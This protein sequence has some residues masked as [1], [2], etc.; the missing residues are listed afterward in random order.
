MTKLFNNQSQGKPM[1]V[2]V[3]GAA[4]AVA[5]SKLYV[6]GGYTFTNGKPTPVKS[7]Q[8][9]DLTTD[10]WAKDG[11]GGAPPALPDAVHS[12]SAAVLDG[13]LYVAG[14]YG[15][16]GKVRGNF[17]SCGTDGGTWGEAPAMPTPRALLQLTVHQGLLWA[18]GGVGADRVAM[19]TV[20]TY[21]P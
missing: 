2:P 11:A 1:P 8:V 15:A 19:Q 6:V 16:D 13:T 7:V 10:T 9:Y 17:L 5:G 3:A 21:Q 20:E 4:S 12:A 18:I 14:G